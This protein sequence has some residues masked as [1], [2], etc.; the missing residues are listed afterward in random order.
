M[1]KSL[2]FIKAVSIVALLIFSLSA[3][4]RGK[5][6]STAESLPPGTH[7]VD[8]IEVIQTSNY[9]YLQVFENDQKFWIAVSRLDAKTGDVIYYTNAMEMKDFKSKELDRVFPSILFVND[10]STTP[11]SEKKMAQ[12][13]GKITAERLTEISVEPVSGG[14]TISELY[15]KKSGFAEKSVKI[16]GVIVKYNKNIMGKNWAHIQDGT[17]SGGKYDLTVTTMD[18]VEEGNV[19]TFEGTIHLDKDFG[20]GYAYDVIMEDAKAIEIKT[21]G[22]ATL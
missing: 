19:V 8:V 11:P 10:P 4:N 13:P 1:K 22:D 15:S 2:N 20:A 16:R 7:A 6:N 9:T 18:A 3:C 5:K 14:I 12:S 17:E 21:N